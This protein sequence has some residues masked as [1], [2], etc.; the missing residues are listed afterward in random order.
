MATVTVYRFEM[1]D[2][3]T[4]QMRTS[5]RWG[6]LNAIERIG[7]HALIHT[8][9]EVHESHL[10]EELEGMTKRNFNPNS[11]IS[12]GFQREVKRGY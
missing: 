12:G 6:T 1:Y 10:G 3:K 11:Q 5:M 7:G 9:I 2:V 4:D 8:A